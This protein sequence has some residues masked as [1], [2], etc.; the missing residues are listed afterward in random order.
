MSSLSWD[1]QPRYTF[2]LGVQ[3]VEELE[4]WMEEVLGDLVERDKGLSLLLYLWLERGVDFLSSVEVVLEFAD[5]DLCLVHPDD[6]DGDDTPAVLHLV[7]MEG[8]GVA[9]ALNQDGTFSFSMLTCTL[10]WYWFMCIS[11]LL[12]I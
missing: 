8:E 2:L 3:E 6:D 9:A 4:E 1:L 10:L 11:L 7:V 12:G 5:R